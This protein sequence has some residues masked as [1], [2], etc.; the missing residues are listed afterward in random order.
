[1]VNLLASWYT[2]NRWIY[3]LQGTWVRGGNS[4]DT[5]S[6]LAGIGYQLDAPH[7]RRVL[8]SRRLARP[9]KRPIMN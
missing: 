1:M 2:E 6:V 4:F 8:I 7:P 9:R 3:Q 5:L